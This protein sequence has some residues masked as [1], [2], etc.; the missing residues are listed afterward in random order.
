M[1]P[2]ADRRRPDFVTARR[3]PPRGVSIKLATSKGAIG[4]DAGTA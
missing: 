1:A 4:A 2:S 3:D